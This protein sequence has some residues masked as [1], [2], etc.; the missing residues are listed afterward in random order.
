M[1]LQIIFR[2]IQ[3]VSGFICSGNP[4]E[5]ETERR[6]QSEE[7]DDTGSSSHEFEDV[8]LRE[9]KALSDSEIKVLI[10]ISE[11]NSHTTGV[12]TTVCY[13]VLNPCGFLYSSVCKLARLFADLRTCWLVVWDKYSSRWLFFNINQPDSCQI[14]N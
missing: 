11:R 3:M 5:C 13:F 4:L 7:E 1:I 8:G 10:Y 2:C 6:Q 14:M 12:P 9:E